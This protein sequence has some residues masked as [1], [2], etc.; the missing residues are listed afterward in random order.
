MDL[1]IY[2][3]TV[4]QIEVELTV[5][6][7]PAKHHCG[8]IDTGHHRLGDCRK[9]APHFLSDTA[10]GKVNAIKRAQPCSLTLAGLYFDPSCSFAQKRPS[11]I[12]GQPG[13]I[14]LVPIRQWLTPLGHW[15]V[16][17]RGR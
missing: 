9:L 14:S 13:D 4:L 10:A 2:R 16:K 1:G 17:R 7:H 5:I 8:D 12:I 11:L 6:I 3:N 15:E